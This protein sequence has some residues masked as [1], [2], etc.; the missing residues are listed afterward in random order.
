MAFNRKILTR[1]LP[2][3]VDI[4]MHD[5]WIGMIAELGGK[6]Y[7][8]K[9]RLTSYRK[10]NSNISPTIIGKSSYKFL[11]QVKF[12]YNLFKELLRRIIVLYGF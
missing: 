10:H 5:I 2:F 3:P 12:R 7:F 11:R 9:E 6:T 4:P 1:S 8:C